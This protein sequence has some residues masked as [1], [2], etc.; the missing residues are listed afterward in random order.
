MQMTQRFPRAVR[1]L[2]RGLLPALATLCMALAGCGRDEARGAEAGEAD[3][4]DRADA[5]W[6]PQALTRV[7][8]LDVAAVRGA[9]GQRLDGGRP[10]PLDADQWERVRK[11]YRRYG[12]GPLWFGPD[13]LLEDRAA[14]LL[15][16][17]VNAHQDA[18]R[19]DRYPLGELARSLGAV[20]DA[21]RPTA[22]QVAAADVMLTASYAALGH[23]LLTGQ[24]DPRSVSQAWFINPDRERVDSALARTLREE[25]LHR[26]IA[27]MRPQDDDYAFLQRQL[28][29]YRQIASR[30][31]WPTV[32]RG[33][34]LKP[35]ESDSP[36]RLAA[37]RQRLQ[38]EGLLAAATTA[39]PPPAE[40]AGRSPAR[41]AGGAVYDPALAGAVAAFQARHGIE[42]DSTLGPETVAAL[43]LSPAYRLW[44]I[45]ANLERYRWLPRSLGSR[46]ILVNVPAFRLEAFDG[47]RKAL[48]MKVIV[49]EEYEDRATPVFSD[50]MEYVVFRPYWM[51]T[52]SIA[53]KEIFPRAAADPGYFAR[54]RYETFEEQGKTRV[55]QRP[56]EKNSLGLVKFMFPNDFNIYLHDTPA[57]SLF[58][59]DVRA[60]SH[61]CIRL[62]KPDQ[63]AL[64]ALGWPPE[65]VRQAM[66]QGPDDRRVNLPRKIPVYI[67][68]FTAYA[69]GGQLYFGNDLY[70]RDDRLIRA[71]SEG[72]VPSAQALR[73]ADALRRF[74]AE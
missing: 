27:G 6:N 73:A 25:P 31:G 42:S 22:A 50:S 15:T 34:E 5:A 36:A 29:H 68:Y 18:L 40:S 52:D 49:G 1:R 37:L 16:A 38:A 43:N 10:A 9:V 20:K 39:P 14:A 55:R 41:P 61:G 67:A 59:E 21:R 72:A 8:G 23:D 17:L 32:P 58:R 74:V 44:Q 24:V 45:A 70:R 4:A 12:Q 66:Q 13:G 11:L 33:K 30:G 62:E 51:V 35:G 60:F 48:E 3:R 19:L 65:R 53:A 56:G 46:Y 2:G 57:D 71:V 28:Q 26:A 54:N 47:G 69:R 63:L 64:F 7:A